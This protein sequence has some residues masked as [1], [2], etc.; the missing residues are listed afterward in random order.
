MQ[1]KFLI[2]GTGR[3]GTTYAAEVFKS[4][5]VNCGHQQ[6]L[7]HQIKEWGDFEGDASYEA[8]PHLKELKGKVIIIHLKRDKQKVID[9]YLRTKT[10]ADG[11]EQSHAELYNS[12]KRFAP[13]V[14]KKKNEHARVTAFYYAWLKHCEKYADFSFNLETLDDK[15]LFKA[16]GHED[17]YDS[18]K[19]ALIPKDINS[20]VDTTV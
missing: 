5:G 4:C 15:E 11:W 17:K 18:E 1:S 3:C 9:S 10:F 12:I 20:H 7:K 16:A 13:E 6:V 8:V 14:L 19:V 2:T